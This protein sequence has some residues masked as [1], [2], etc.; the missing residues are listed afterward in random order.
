MI[1]LAS[2][3]ISCQPKIANEAP[4]PFSKLSPAPL[5]FFEVQ[6]ADDAALQAGTAGTPPETLRGAA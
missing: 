1:C 5:S 4:F 6:Q 2:S 3:S